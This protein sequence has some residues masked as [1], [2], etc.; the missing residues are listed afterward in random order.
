M[1]AAVVSGILKIVSN[2]LAPLL[3]KEYSLI[4]GVQKHLLELKDQVQEINCW[5]EAVGDKV[6]PN[7]PAFNW[8]RK[9]KDI[10]LMLMALL[11]SS[12]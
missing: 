7:T 8:L 12:S 3:I 6:S 5:L 2:K 1:E 4:V 11:M 9:L 10:A